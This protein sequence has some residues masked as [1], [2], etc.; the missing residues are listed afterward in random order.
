MPLHAKSKK[1]I[2]EEEMHRFRH[3]ELHSGSGKKKV[4]KR[5]Q[6]IAIALSEARRK[7]YK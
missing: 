5:S 3:G 4:K 6:A 1:G 2:I 7:G